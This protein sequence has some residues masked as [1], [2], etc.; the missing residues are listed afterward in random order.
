MCILSRQ[1]MTRTLRGYRMME[2]RWRRGEPL[3]PPRKR[4]AAGALDVQRHNAAAYRLD[5]L[6]AASADDRVQ[7]SDVRDLV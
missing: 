6:L 7:G 4:H 2:R 1:R 5:G 3:P